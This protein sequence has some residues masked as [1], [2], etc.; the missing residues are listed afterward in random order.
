MKLIESPKAG[1]VIDAT[2]SMYPSKLEVVEGAVSLSPA[3]NTVFGFVLEGRAVVGQEGSSFALDEGSYFSL[4]LSKG[5]SISASGKTVLITRFGF[6]GQLVVGRIEQRGRLSYI[7]SCSDSM[8]VYPARQGDPVF[9]HLHFPAGIV[10]TQHTHPSIRLGIVARGR[11]EAFGPKVMGEKDMWT[12]PLVKGCVFLLEEQE[13]HS[14][15]TDKRYDRLQTET[16]TMDVIAYHPDSDW[17]PTDQGHPMLNRTY[18]GANVFARGN[19]PI[20]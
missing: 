12:Q 9:N 15:R 13:M 14:F 4:P 3:P 1:D 6:L 5:A 7:D 16:S 11:G 10:Q 2:D 20:T 8:L 17:G 18:I 19:T